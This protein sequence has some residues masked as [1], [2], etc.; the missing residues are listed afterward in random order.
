MGDTI[1]GDSA[2]T[3]LLD[4]TDEE[5][6]AEGGECG[7]NDLRRL[8]LLCLESYCTSPVTSSDIVKM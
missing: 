4:E 7:D 6:S 3:L 1:K 2:L 5:D 8:S